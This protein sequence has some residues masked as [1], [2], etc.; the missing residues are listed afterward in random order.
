MNVCF[1]CN[2]D[3]GLATDWSPS[4]DVV[5][6]TPSLIREMEER[7]IPKTEAVVNKMKMYSSAVTF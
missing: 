7:E 2:L 4:E 5:P 1:L 6:I 3:Y